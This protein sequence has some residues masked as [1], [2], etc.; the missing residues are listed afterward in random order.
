MGTILNDVKCIVLAADDIHACL[1]VSRKASELNIPLVEGWAIP[2]AN[3]RV[4]T[5]D[6][7]TLEDVYELPTKGKKVHEL[8]K[9]EI[10][11]ANGGSR[12]RPND[13][14]CL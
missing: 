13:H 4:Y 5:K 12:H 10:H 8:S 2:Y 3:V 7:P 6:T 14:L 1:I 11:Q 9:A